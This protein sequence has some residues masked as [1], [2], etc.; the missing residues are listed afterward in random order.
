MKKVLVLY[1]SHYGSTK[2][3]AEWI[4]EELNGDIYNLNNVNQNNLIEYD[5]IILGIALYP[6]K[7]NGIE[8]FEDNY[9]VIKDK[10]L[11]VFACGLSDFD[12]AENRNIITKRFQKIIPENLFE[13][14]KIFFLRGNID[15]RKISLKHRIMMGFRKKQIQRKGADKMDEEDKLLLETY[16]KKIDFTEKKN[17]KEIIEYC[18]K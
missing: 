12:K 7:V 18:K 14:I 17:I 5:V 6:E 13:D 2:K 9:K 8:F 16:G 11:I 3:Y 1:F 15:Y 10:K 4:A